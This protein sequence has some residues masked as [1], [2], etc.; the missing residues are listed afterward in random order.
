VKGIGVVSDRRV[1][2]TCSA[3]A[4]FVAHCT[5]TMT[6]ASTAASRYAF[7]LLLRSLLMSSSTSFSCLGHFGDS[8]PTLARLAPHLGD[9]KK[10]P[11]SPPASSKI[12][13]SNVGVLRGDM[14][15]PGKSSPRDPRDSAA[16]LANL[17]VGS[18][19][20]RGVNDVRWKRS[21]NC[22]IRLLQ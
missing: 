5:A 22:L 9:P 10:F 6:A 12:F 20:F 17:G 7:E 16:V 19:A 1:A 13:E 11:S 3:D 8:R 18:I 2:S 21:T 15:K 4:D 14:R